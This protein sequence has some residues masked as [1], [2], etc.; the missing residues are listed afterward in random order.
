MAGLRPGSGT[1]TMMKPI[2][3]EGQ[4]TGRS[5]PGQAL[6]SW[7]AALIVAALFLAV[8]LLVFRPGYAVNDDIS[9]IAIAAGYPGGQ[10]LP[11]LMFS[12]VL[13]GLLLNLLYRLP[14]ALNWEI[15][16][17][18]TLQFLSVWGL[19]A[20]ILSGPWRRTWKA[21]GIL[22][23]VSCASTFL[24][25]ITFT[26]TAG[27]TAL[28]GCCL[29]LAACRARAEVDRKLLAFGG[30]LI[31]AGSLVRLES[32]LLALLLMLPL[33]GLG[34]GAFRYRYLAFGLLA[35]GL[36]V[37]GGFVFDRLYLAASPAWQTF[38][39]YNQAR[40]AV[41]DTPRLANLGSA[42]R[43]V[44]WSAN[45]LKMFAH[46][47]FPD[48]HTFSLPR[49]DYLI[50]HVPGTTT[51]LGGAIRSA[52]GRWLSLTASPYVLSLA[53]LWLALLAFARRR[54]TVLS[55][56]VLT[57]ALLAL[58]VALAWSAKL[59]NRVLELLLVDGLLFGF[60][61]LAWSEPSGR[62]KPFVGR[63]AG[64]VV[65]LL[66]AAAL[67][68][69]VGRAVLD[70][71]ASRSEQSAYRQILSQLDGLGRSGVLPADALVVSPAY[72]IPLEWANPLVLDFP[73]VA[74]L[75][76][77]WKTFSPVYDRLLRQRGAASL[78]GGLLAGGKLFLMSST[79]L[80]NGVAQFLQEH[81]Q[82]RVT[83]LPLYSLPNAPAAPEYDDVHLFRFVPA[84]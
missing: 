20:V 32:A 48:A 27:L 33:L 78:D 19:L 8:H 37:A 44:N 83:A 17:F 34:R 72:G 65:G 60:F 45:D 66:L 39:I 43:Q 84:P 71:R 9:M 14:G 18:L 6:P 42:I 59:P 22:L 82:A 3:E 49:L 31:F 64:I 81:D 21:V 68:L 38:A 56:S 11:F 55:L 25:E 36:L 62:L 24:L 80:A 73:Q 54:R 52:A 57:L 46:W 53:G 74:Y 28:A 26:T 50:R 15:W 58:S 35:A 40:S 13:L 76:L 23:V 70:T 63:A 4:P 30:L 16:I 5:G 41:Q 75:D 77:G 29:I 7:L 1:T 12:N 69:V 2:I 10:P 47:F 67:V 61:L 79:D 51:S